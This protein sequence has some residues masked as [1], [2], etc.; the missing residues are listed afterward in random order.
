MDQ[1]A[2]ARILEPSGAA[3]RETIVQLL[4][5]A[6]WQEIETAPAP[7][8]DRAPPPKQP[9]KKAPARPPAPGGGPKPR[10]PKKGRG[11]RR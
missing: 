11:G 7:K 8:P 6:Y 10:P 2:P 3:T 1:N 9:K 5:E 4:R